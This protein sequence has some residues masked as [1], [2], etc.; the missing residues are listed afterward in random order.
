MHTK[1]ILYPPFWRV[2]ICLFS[3]SGSDVLLLSWGDIGW[4]SNSSTRKMYERPSCGWVHKH[5]LFML[6]TRIPLLSSDT[7]SKKCLHLLWN[8][9][10]RVPLSGMIMDFCCG[11]CLIG[12]QLCLV[13]YWRWLGHT[14]VSS[15]GFL[16]QMSL[17]DDIPLLPHPLSVVIRWKSL[18][19]AFKSGCPH[20]QKA[21]AR[22]IW[23]RNW[24]R[25]SFTASISGLGS[26]HS[27][28]QRTWCPDLCTFTNHNFLGLS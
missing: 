9:K 5:Y 15:P 23:A 8:F 7:A 21:K 17:N 22:G 20:H 16:V 6:L 2:C 25:E 14:L 3:T 28:T 4:Q 10:H 13:Y 24:L 1:I 19:E 12:R 26:R 11:I 18:D 27:T